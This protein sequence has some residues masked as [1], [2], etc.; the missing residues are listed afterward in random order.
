[1]ELQMDHISKQFQDKIAVDH[2]SLCIT[3]GVWSLLG[4]NGAGK[5][6]LMRMIAGIMKPN[7]GNINY[8]GIPIAV[9]GEAY[10]DRL[11]YLPQEF[12]FY[13]EFT[14]QAYLEYVAALKG[15]IKEHTRNK[16][17]ALLQKLSLSDLKRKKIK[18][19]SGGTKRR[20]GI[21]QA[22]LNDPDI[23]LLDE[24]TSGLDPGER[25]RLRNMLAEFAQEK[26]VFIS[27]H[28]V[29]DVEYLA[30]RHAILKDGKIISVGTTEEL[31][32]QL[33]GKVWTCKIPATELSK[34]EKILQIVTLRNEGNE[35]D[36]E[37][38]TLSIRYLAQES[39][40]PGSLATTPRL[41]D[42]YLW[43]FPQGS[44]EKEGV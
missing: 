42:L 9:L 33:E 6:T 36:A 37:N 23:L 43:L 32:T 38:G 16:I 41:E 1:M 12:G 27:T 22:L 13:P 39:A 29:P 31:V 14:V 25:I 28:I 11:G 3:P 44:L 8:D 5:T 26:I 40:V 35:G 2:V 21:A 24:P 20:V 30:T 17:E 10:R 4:A 19:L 18:T 7:T 15:L 34:Y